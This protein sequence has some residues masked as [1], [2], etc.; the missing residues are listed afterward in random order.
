MEVAA[1]LG[2]MLP[3]LGFSWSNQEF[4]AFL[5]QNLATKVS[6]RVK[7]QKGRVGNTER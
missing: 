6:K 7:F 1:V 2:G 5:H 4:L 3:T